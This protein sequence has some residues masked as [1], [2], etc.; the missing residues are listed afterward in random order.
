MEYIY[1]AAAAAHF[2]QVLTLGGNGQ[3]QQ[4]NKYIPFPV[5]IWMMNGT[6]RWMETEKADTLC[7]HTAVGKNGKYGETQGLPD[8]YSRNNLFPRLISRIEPPVLCVSIVS[9]DAG[10][11]E[12]ATPQV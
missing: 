1:S 2:R 4:L 12:R 7:M 5:P 6:T 9:P 8:F 3:Q 11:W 10:L